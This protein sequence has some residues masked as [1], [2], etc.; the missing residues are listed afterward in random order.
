METSPFEKLFKLPLRNG[1]T[2]PK[3]V[4][5]IGVKFV[6]MGEI[7]SIDR[8]RNSPMERA[9]LTD[10]E[11]ETSL[12]EDGDLL[13]A[14]QSLVAEGAGKISIFLGDDEA[15]TFESHIIRARL[16]KKAADP[17]YYY[18][19]FRSFSGRSLI[20]SI[21]EQVAAAGIRGSD[22]AKLKVPVP[23]LQQ[24]HAV[25]D[26][27]SALDNK[28]ENNRLMNETLEEMARAI[29]KSW[30]VDFD[31]VHAKA[32]GEQPA[33]MNAETAALFPSGFGED[34]LPEG[35]RTET[36]GN[37]V[38]I[39]N[40]YS[41]KSKDWQEAGIPVV[42]IGSVKPSFVDVQSVSYVS[43]TIA[44]ERSNFR[45]EVG[46]V[47]IGLTGYVGEVGRVP[48]CDPTPL[49]NQRVGRVRFQNKEFD[50]FIY[51]AL[52]QSDFKIYAENQAHGS[53]QP[54]VSTKQLKAFQIVNAGDKILNVFRQL[55]KPLFEKSIANVSE[56]ANLAN[57]RDTLLPKL[58]SGEIRVRDAE[59]EVEAV[60]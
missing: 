38:D 37:F 44:A 35:W 20:R 4:R 6:N 15:C 34:D 23:A 50:P 36:L 2:K 28:I 8:L 1:L 40:G 21:V 46:D 25:A 10:K 45:L 58:M 47:L 9:P 13:F 49:L 18:Y 3:R 57:L 17:R 41:F 19:F 52:R 56:N 29:F 27:L 5:G 12:L 55:T 16:D 11:K 22:L 60:T 24:Q 32:R 39:Q 59:K 51:T 48:K 33:H 30:F 42:K 53:A 54:N 43:D 14:R 31:P 26:L 7:F